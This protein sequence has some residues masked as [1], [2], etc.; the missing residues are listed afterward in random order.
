MY[1]YQYLKII[2]STCSTFYE[3]NIIE[4]KKRI[5]NEHVVGV[6]FTQSNMCQGI[7]TFGGKSLH[8]IDPREINPYQRVGNSYKVY[9]L[10]CRKARYKK[11]IFEQQRQKKPI[12]KYKFQ[13]YQI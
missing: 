1:M 13:I 10:L 3:M 6:D 4:L 12:N 8:C 9:Q 5:N 2:F 7:R 11:E